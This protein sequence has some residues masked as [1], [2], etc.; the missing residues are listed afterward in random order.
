MSVLETKL[1]L[2]PGDVIGCY[3]MVRVIGHGAMGPVYLAERAKG[4][5]RQQA[6]I[7]LLLTGAHCPSW[8]DLK[9]SN[10]LVDGTGQP[11]IT[12]RV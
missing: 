9:P 2:S 3:H 11:K 6:V 8:R 7:K 1:E 5:I 12:G 4:E 10:I